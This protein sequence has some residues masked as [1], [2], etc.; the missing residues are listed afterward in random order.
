MQVYTFEN[1]ELVAQQVALSAEAALDMQASP[2]A[3]HAQDEQ[4]AQLELKVIGNVAAGVPIEAI[5]QN[6]AI[7]GVPRRLFRETP[8]YLLRVKGDSMEDSGIFDGDLIA[9]KKSDRANIG[10]FVVARMGDDV[11]FKELQVANGKP[12]LVPHNKKYQP[13]FVAPEDLV[14][15]GVFVGLIRNSELH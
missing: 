2:N 6:A 8:T 5:Q 4:F 15:E 10:D 14:V 9:I 1:K 7:V 13:I 3:Q 12:V 11:T